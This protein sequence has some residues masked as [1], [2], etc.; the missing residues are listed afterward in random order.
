[1]Q[2]GNLG[3]HVYLDVRGLKKTFYYVIYPVIKRAF[4]AVCMEVLS[5]KGWTVVFIDLH[6]V[7]DTDLLG[8][9]IHVN[10]REGHGEKVL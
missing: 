2:K 1:M 10:D 6:E 9:L 7:K 5:F 3:K 8:I 4:L